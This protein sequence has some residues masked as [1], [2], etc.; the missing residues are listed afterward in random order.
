[1]VAG[2]RRGKGWVRRVI[3]VVRRVYDDGLERARKCAKAPVFGREIYNVEIAMKLSAITMM[4]LILS[5]AA[6]RTAPPEP[7]SIEVTS[8]GGIAGRGAGSFAI[9]STGKV[10]VTTMTRKSCTFQATEDEMRR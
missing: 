8:S 1:M 3:G 5:C 7:W 2:E 10:A 9:D 6:A 4:L